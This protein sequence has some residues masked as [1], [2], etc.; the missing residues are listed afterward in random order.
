MRR[1]GNTALGVEMSSDR[2][3]SRQARRAIALPRTKEERRKE[4][5]ARIQGRGPAAARYA[6]PPS[7]FK[8]LP[9]PTR[10]NSRFTASGSDALCP[11]RDLSQ[12]Y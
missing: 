1:A 6:V 3:I 4:Q 7:H 9:S 5:S 12:R 11:L 2:R 10:E 8:A